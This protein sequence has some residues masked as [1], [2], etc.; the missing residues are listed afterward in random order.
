V[1]QACAIVTVGALVVFAPWLIKNAILDG[2]PVSPFVWGTSAFDHF[3]QVY[4]LRA[5]TGLGPLSVI[6]APIQA[7]VFGREQ[8]AP[9]GG[10]TG[11][12]AFTLLPLA[13]IGWKRRE[14]AERDLISALAIFALPPYIVWAAG[15]A[16]SWYL[17]QTRL[18]YPIFP[19]FLVIG[20][21][22]AE[23]LRAQRLRPDPALIARLIAAAAAMIALWG[24]L[25]ATILSG[26]WLV[27]LG[28]SPVDAYLTSRMGATFAAFQQ[29]NA[30]PG[31]AKVQFLWE[32]R[33]FYCQKTCIPDSGIDLWWDERQTIGDPQQ[34]IQSW[35]ASGVQYV[36]ISDGGLK[37][38]TTDTQEKKYELLTP[39]DLAA[40]DQMRASDL[41][42]IWSIPGAYSLYQIQG[43]AP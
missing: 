1:L 23:G 32:P 30:L 21:A 12:L 16:T 40:L 4:Y 42:L 22:A 10:S 27:E 8:I 35:R 34:I 6:L 20:A 11:V 36:L 33:T 19:A 15:I 7:T 28:L 37:F 31:P 29:I 41:K 25:F 24:A 5:G 9:Y 3:D 13:L 2:N 39:A 14:P 18:L 17:V 38:L 26:G 43:S